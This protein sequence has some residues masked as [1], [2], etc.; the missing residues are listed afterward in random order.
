MLR[1]E[2][3]NLTVQSTSLFDIFPDYNQ[4]FQ[5]IFWF[6]RVC[7][8]HFFLT[9]GYQFAKFLILLII[10]RNQSCRTRSARMPE[11]AAHHLTY[12]SNR[13]KRPWKECHLLH[14]DAIAPFKR[15]L[16]MNSRPWSFTI[17]KNTFSLNIFYRF[18]KKMIMHVSASPQKPELRKAAFQKL[19][20]TG[21]RSE[22][23]INLS[24]NGASLI[25][26]M[27]KPNRKLLGSYTFV[28]EH[29][30]QIQCITHNRIS[31]GQKRY[32]NPSWSDETQT[33]DRIALSG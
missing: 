11:N 30:T 20:T 31:K 18:F 32:K 15:A 16:K 9:S 21:G 33:N 28:S 22:M 25:G 7:S 26:Y 4:Q 27:Q 17:R 6:Y 3:H 12:F 19:S 8:G 10:S 23:K 13:L 5:L 29:S 24:M 1:W 2:Y 14:Q